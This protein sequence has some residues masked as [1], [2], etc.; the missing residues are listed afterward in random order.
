MEKE[1]LKFTKQYLQEQRRAEVTLDKVSKKASRTL[2]NP[3]VGAQLRQQQQVV[4]DRVADLEALRWHSLRSVLTEERR[5]Y[6]NVLA[7]ICD[8]MK[9]SRAYGRESITPINTALLA[10]EPLCQDPNR[11]PADFNPFEKRGGTMMLQAGPT[12][13]GMTDGFGFGG[14]GRMGG[15]GGLRGPNLGGRNS[16]VVGS[17]GMGGGPGRGSMGPSGAPQGMFGQRGPPVGPMTAMRAGQYPGV[18]PQQQQQQMQ[19]QQMQQMQMQQQQQRQQSS[20][21]SPQQQQQQQ[22]QRGMD[23]RSFANVRTSSSPAANPTPRDAMSLPPVNTAAGP[24]ILPANH[25]KALHDYTPTEDGQIA[26]SKGDVIDVESV[27]DDWAF[28]KNT[29]TGE[30]GWIPASFVDGIGKK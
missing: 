23:A 6:V 3:E 26:L 21:S 5:R 17:G 18:S 7:G 24:A 27:E 30:S 10:C 16:G 13:G 29:Q 1:Y 22:Q 25:H 11:L 14:P 4:A 19:M 12:S 15:M 2:G 20:S 8:M 9:V 28:G